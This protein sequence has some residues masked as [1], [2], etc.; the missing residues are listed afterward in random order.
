MR[1]LVELHGGTVEVDSPGRGLGATFTIKLPLAVVH[2]SEAARSLETESLRQDLTVSAHLL[3]LPSLEGV[4]VLLVDEDRD[5]LNMLAM[6]LTERRARVQGVTSAAEALEALE[7]FEAD[8]LVSDLTIP[9]E[10][11]YALIAKVRTLG[12]EDAR[13]IPAVALTAYVRIE[14]RALA[15]AAGFNMFVP[16]PVEPSERVLAIANLAAPGTNESLLSH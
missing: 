15:L 5:T 3:P 10:D 9:G 12:S 4:K 1:H 14:D 2:E 6:M 8:V 16:K 7:W 13:R 11:G